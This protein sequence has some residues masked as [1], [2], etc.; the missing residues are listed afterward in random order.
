MSAVIDGLGLP[1]A[2]PHGSRRVSVNEGDPGYRVFQHCGG[3]GSKWTVMLDGEELEGAVTAD[4]DAGYV[5]VLARNAKGE[6]YGIN[7]E[8]A[9]E[10]RY[11]RVQVF[12]DGVEV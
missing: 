4:P 8:V 1:I 3:Y 9:R 10:T 5:V 11:G 2:Q 12:C 7:G 6:L